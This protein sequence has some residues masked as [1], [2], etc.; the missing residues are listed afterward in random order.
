MAK[1]SKKSKV[2]SKKTKATKK[3]VVKA[4]GKKATGKKKVIKKKAAPK[5][6]RP[7]GGKAKAKKKAVKKTAKKKVVKKVAKKK[8]APKKAKK[9]APK[10]VKKAVAKPARQAGGKPIAKAVKAKV[11]A[12]IVKAVEQNATTSTNHTPTTETFKK[13]VTH[14]K[15]GD[16]APFF[17]GVDQNGNR[18][19]SLD[20]PGKNIVLFFYPED[21]TETCTIE[22]CNLRDEFQYLSDNNYQVIGVSPDGVDSHE[23]F[24]SKY[25]LP[26]P[27]IADTDKNIIKAYDVWGPKQLFGR[28][29]D[30]L[31]RTTFVIGFEGN[32]KNVITDVKAADHARQI[33][34]M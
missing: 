14:L 6:A 26:Y 16:P 33:T 12:E 24:A 4:K 23:R 5:P 2:K 28:I 18:I 19:T 7:A 25:S 20:F 32:I 1:K 13:H 15:A 31:L 27:L 34:S 11:V 3:K 9:A 22:A 21:D 17:E 29:Y 30:G 10:K 8:S